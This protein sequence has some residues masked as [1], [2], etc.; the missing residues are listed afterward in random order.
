[1]NPSFYT[2]DFRRQMLENYRKASTCLSEYHEHR[3]NFAQI[4]LAADIPN[5]TSLCQSFADVI[6]DNLNASRE[7]FGSKS[8]EF[9]MA[10]TYVLD[11]LAVTKERRHEWKDQAELN[12]LRLFDLQEITNSFSI[13]SQRTRIV[14]QKYLEQ[15]Q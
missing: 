8:L 15:S 4:I 14:F 6:L 11:F 7:R 10:A 5:D 12:S 1:M 9:M 2:D 3:Q 13:L